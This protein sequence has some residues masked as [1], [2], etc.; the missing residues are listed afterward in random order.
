[1]CPRCLS[2]Y[3][4]CLCPAFPASWTGLPS[5]KPPRPR[6]RRRL[7]LTLFALILLLS[8]C[9]S[10]TARPSP[11]ILPIKPNLPSLQITAE[12]GIMMDKRDTAELLIYIDALERACGVQ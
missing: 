6:L 10:S 1:M 9:V 4:A 12:G 5:A 7:A 3:L 11:A 2:A 8:S